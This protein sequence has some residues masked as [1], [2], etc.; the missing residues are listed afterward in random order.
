MQFCNEIGVEKA[1]QFKFA[2]GRISTRFIFINKGDQVEHCYRGANYFPEVLPL[3]LLHIVVNHNSVNSLDTLQSVS[4]A[5]SL[6]EG[7]LGIV[8]RC[9]TNGPSI[10]VNGSIGPRCGEEDTSSEF[11]NKRPPNIENGFA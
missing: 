11:G 8:R 1:E 3:P 5:T 7:S 10:S 4:A 6:F 2:N 9:P